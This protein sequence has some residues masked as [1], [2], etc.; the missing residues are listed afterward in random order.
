MHKTLL[1][2]LDELDDNNAIL[3]LNN[4]GIPLYLC[5][6]PIDC[7]GNTFTYLLEKPSHIIKMTEYTTYIQIDI[8]I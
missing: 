4:K 1:D 7:I 3:I 6:S 5:S 8:A 2:I